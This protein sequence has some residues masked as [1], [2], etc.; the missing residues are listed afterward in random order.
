MDL[1]A[2]IFPKWLAMLLESNPKFKNK[3]NRIIS[4]ESSGK[5]EAKINNNGL[6]DV[7]IGY[8]VDSEKC[9]QRFI[10]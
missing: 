8:L 6:K 1:T 5:S 2:N 10:T 4:G 3:F 9:L 7:F